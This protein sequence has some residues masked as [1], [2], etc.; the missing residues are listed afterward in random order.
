ML[1]DQFSNPVKPGTV[2]YFETT[3]GVIQG[4]GQTNEDGIVNVDLISGNP[5]PIS[6]VATVTASTVNNNNVRIQEKLDIVMSGSRANITANPTTF[7]IDN[8]GGASF[9]YTVEDLNGNPMAAGTQISIEAGD[10]I[11]LTGDTNFE[12]GNNINAGPGATE[13]SFSIR[14]TDIE[15]NNESDL[16]I[17]ISVN[18]PS[19]NTTTYSG[20]QGT[21]SKSTGN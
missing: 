2:I 3:G 21:R 13:F 1:G 5:R 18:T 12:L 17:L 4:S 9:D 7:D 16:T 8:G 15:S 6:G 10:G 11:E 14:D 19:G 20:I